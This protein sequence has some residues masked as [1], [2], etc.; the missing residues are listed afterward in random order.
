MGVWRGEE[1]WVW[2]GGWLGKW[3]LDGSRWVD[4]QVVRWVDRC[5]EAID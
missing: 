5:L 4:G 3:I 2:V 1:A